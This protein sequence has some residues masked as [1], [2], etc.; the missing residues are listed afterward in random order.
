MQSFELK[1]FELNYS[2][3]FLPC[4]HSLG[5]FPFCVAGRLQHPRPQLRLT[6]TPNVLKVLWI[7]LMDLSKILIRKYLVKQLVAG[8]VVIL[9][10]SSCTTSLHVH[11]S[12]EKCA[13]MEIVAWVEAVVAPPIF[14]MW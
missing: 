9:E 14:H 5:T 8:C 6:L 4:T 2:C 7:V 13:K 11:P 12:L 1:N 3:C 10:Q